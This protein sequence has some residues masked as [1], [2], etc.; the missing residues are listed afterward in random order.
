MQM[1]TDLIRVLVVEDDEISAKAVGLML[2][3]LA[4]SVEI[5]ESGREA[6][7]GF[8]HHKYDLVLMGWQMPVMDGFEATA[9]I[10]TMLHG[11]RTPIIGTTAGRDRAECM[12]AG[13]NDL[14]PKPF[15]IEKLRQVLL[16]WTSWPGV[17]E[18]GGCRTGA[19]CETLP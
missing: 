16:R 12:A 15:Q 2:E 5:A 7:E 13:M 10:R 3:R 14:M 9:R 17:R 6:I 11:E 18:S 19:H 4:C 1:S 8:R